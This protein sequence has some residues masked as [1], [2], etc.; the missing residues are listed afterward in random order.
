VWIPHEA[1]GPATICH[2]H[3]QR[4]QL[5]YNAVILSKTEI[6]SMAKEGKFVPV[7]D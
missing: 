6:P 3:Q 2:R 5:F 7:F 4:N 1:A